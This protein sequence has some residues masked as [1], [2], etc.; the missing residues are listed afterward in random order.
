MK[1]NISLAIAIALAISMAISY[2]IPLGTSQTYTKEV[3]PYIG[4]V[5]NPVGVGQDILL[6]IGITDAVAYPMTGW[7]GLTVT[8]TKPDGNTET[9][10]PFKTDTTGGTG[11]TYTPT[12]AGTYYFQTNWPEYTTVIASRGI[13]P[14]T[15]MKAA[16]SEKLGVVVQE[17]PIPYYPGAALPSEYWSRPIDSQLREWSTIA[18]NWMAI[19]A[20]LYAPY[21]DGPESPHIL[22]TRPIKTGGIIGEFDGLSHHIGDAYEGLFNEAVIMNGVLY[23][24]RFAVNNRGGLDSQG[25][26]A[27]DLHTGEELWF[28]NNT[29]LSFGQN[30][31]WDSFNMHGAFDY[32]WEVSGSTWKA[33]DAFSGEYVYTMENVPSGSNLYGENNEIIRYTLDQRNGW[34][35][36]WNST[37]VIN[38]QTY[39]SSQDGSWGRYIGG[40]RIYDATGGIQWNVTI[41]QGLPG[42]A[43]A[44][45]LNDR[46][47]GFDF[48]GSKVTVW[49]L[50]LTNRLRRTTTL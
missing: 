9:L 6:H 46:M 10:G 8:V 20:N 41:P 17:D 31:Y 40:S 11:T 18:G 50:D 23:Y 15:L 34:L 13:Q 47:I 44:T 29:R 19:P 5:P 3:Y 25:I 21:N 37:K 49:G 42:T 16:I 33:Y 7:E 30:F 26:Y 36:M 38:P 45:F 43:R 22:W 24:N 35:T 12:I 28:R 2:T 32:L 48:T 4:A 14:D 39:G 1:R 27:V